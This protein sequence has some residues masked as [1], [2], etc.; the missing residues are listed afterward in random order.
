M[1]GM[2]TPPN[3][4]FMVVTAEYRICK[5]CKAGKPVLEFQEFENRHGKRYTRGTCNA[6]LNEQKRKPKNAQ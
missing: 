6:C 4:P 3:T 1:E 2:N 5:K